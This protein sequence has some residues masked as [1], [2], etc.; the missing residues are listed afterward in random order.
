MAE[1][2]LHLNVWTPAPDAAL[3]PVM[4]WLHSGG[5]V[6][7]VACTDI[8]N[9][10]NLARDGDVVVVSVAQRLNVFGYLYL[11]ELSGGAYPDSGNAGQLDLVL[12]LE[13][14]RDNIAQFGGDPCNITLFGESGGGAK[15]SVLMAMPA[16]QGL[17][18]KAIVQSGPMIKAAPPQRATQA[19]LFILESL[20]IRS[21]EVDRLQTEPMERLIEA[22]GKAESAGHMRMFAPVL[23]GRSLVRDPFSPDAP[24]SAASIPLLIGFLAAETTF[25]LGEP[26]HFNLTW[27]N[28]PKF[29]GPHLGVASPDEIISAA[30]RLRPGSSP[31]DLFFELTTVQRFHRSSVALAERKSRQSAPV[32]V[33]YLTWKAPADRGRWRSPHTM[34]IPLVFRNLAAAHSLLGDGP[35][36]IKLSESLSNA[37]ISFARTGNPGHAGLPTWPRY[38]PATAPTMVFDRPPQLEY[39]PT[40]ALADAFGET[41]FWHYTI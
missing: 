22:Y 6:C 38:E 7:G 24:P 1:D 13:W 41:P 11:A 12:A 2:C 14:I 30:R 26:A 18:H 34:D 3:R 10:T 19:A 9:G 15:I 28:L 4:V 33:Y 32:F 8:T 36:P 27:D 29:I 17:F 37:W 35:D 31:S 5:F 20:G 21:D 39:A 25:L 40:R 16:A 23:D